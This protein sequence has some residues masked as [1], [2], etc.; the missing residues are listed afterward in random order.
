MQAIEID[1]RPVPVDVR[2]NRRARRLI[3]RVDQARGGVIVVAPSRR[4]VRDAVKFAQGQSGW[5]ADR[6]KEMPSVIPFA[7]GAVIPLRG[8]THTICHRADAKGGVWPEVRDEA[9]LIVTGEAQFVARRVGDYLKR[10]ARHSLVAET[11]RLCTELKIKRPPIALR[12]PVT[13]WGSC[14][15]RSGLSYSWRLV[16][17]PPHVLSYVVGHEVA[18]LRHMDHSPAFWALVR[19]LVGEP[20]AAVAWLR[21]EGRGLHRFGGKPSALGQFG[22]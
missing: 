9:T 7:P 3:V 8:R 1:G 6:L 17:A 11:D 12:D 19:D 21:R 22:A 5:I 2:I 15:R 4:A 14:S 18:H 16:M 10:E 13:R 20:S